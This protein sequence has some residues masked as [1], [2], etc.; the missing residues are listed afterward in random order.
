MCSA[1]LLDPCTIL[2]RFQLS[3]CLNLERQLFLDESYLSLSQSPRTVPVL[4]GEFRNIARKRYSDENVLKLLREIDVHLHKGLDV[5]SACRK[6]GNSDKT[7]Y[8]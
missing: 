1:V 8:Y 4:L 7:H 6:A 5:V 2:N 3:W